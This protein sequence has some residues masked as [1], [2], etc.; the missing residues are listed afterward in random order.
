MKKRSVYKII[1]LFFLLFVHGIGYGN[2]NSKEQVEKLLKSGGKESRDKNYPKAI[3]IFKEVQLL[4]ETNNWNDLQIK[5]LNDM[6]VAY[7]IISDYDKAMECYLDAYKI[8]LKISDQKGEIVLLNNIADLYSSDQKFG[9]AKEYYQ[10]ALVI[11]EKMNDP[12]RI[13][14]LYVSLSDIANDENNLDLAEEYID[15][16]LILLK[17]TAKKE[18]FFEAEMTKAKTLYKKKEY[19]S[20]ER[21]ILDIVKEYKGEIEKFQHAVPLF[22]LASRIYQEQNK[23]EEALSYAKQAF[24]YSPT[25]TEYINIYERLSELYWENNSAALAWKYKD[26]VIVMKD[27]LYKVNIRENLETNHIHFKLLNSERQLSENKAKQKSER[28]L[29]TSIL[30]FVII[31]AI[32]LIWLF[33]IQSIRNKQWKQITELELEKEKNKKQILEQETKE[34]ETLALLEQERLNIENLRLEQQLK[35]QEA[36]NLLEEERLQNEVNEKLLLKQQM[37]EQ[38]MERILEQERLN[39]K[40]EAKN[41][42]LIARALS[43]SDRNK[44]LKEIIPVLSDIS[45][46]LEDFSLDSVIRKLKIQLKDSVEWENF[47]MQSEQIN[48]SLFS[49]LKDDYPHLTANDIYFLSYIYLNLSN[50]KIAYLLDISPEAC[51]KKKQR[52]ATKMGL[53][54]GE[55]YPFLV[56]KTKFFTK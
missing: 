2:S 16:G 50:K 12:L 7:K 49:S 55:L 36:L 41:K 18:T 31:L 30:V 8:V 37:K 29:F 53:K 26:S 15:L 42:Q 4:A 47:L 21:L 51:R 39:Q 14:Q 40:I 45:G 25:L 28:I 54:L 9:Q 19:L 34:K 22:L 5:A 11:A 48:P 44:M 17:N 3:K 1:P 32:I 35:E 24:L 10:K 56:N 23:Q 46:K 38:E 27:S 20:A 6:G 52:L 13:G 33:R 43:H